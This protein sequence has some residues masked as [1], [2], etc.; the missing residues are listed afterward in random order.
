MYC[1]LSCEL[2]VKYQSRLLFLKV[3]KRL[4]VPTNMSH[5]KALTAK[6]AQNKASTKSFVFLFSLKTPLVFKWKCSKKATV[7]N[8]A[9]SLP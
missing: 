9:G 4:F 5:T 7:T 3:L 1:M 8:K 6:L 2:T